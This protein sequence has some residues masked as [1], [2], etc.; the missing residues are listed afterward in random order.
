MMASENETVAEIVNEMR[1]STEQRYCS[2]K[3]CQVKVYNPILDFADRIETAHKREVEKLSKRLEYVI[4]DSNRTCGLCE[5]SK[6]ILKLQDCL[7]EAI[8]NVCFKCRFGNVLYPYYCGNDCDKMAKWRK[9]LEG[10]K[11]EGK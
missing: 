5:P 1:G 2:S 4:E 7:K 9:A 8:D 10:A 6:K 3:H 11:D